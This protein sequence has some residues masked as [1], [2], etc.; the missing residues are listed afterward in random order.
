[1]YALLCLWSCAQNG[2]VKYSENRADSIFKLKN[3][4]KYHNLDRFVPDTLSWDSRQSHYQEVDSTTF[5]KL[6][7][8]GNNKFS[9]S[10]NDKAF[11]YSWQDRDSNF[12]DVIILTQ[13][14]GSYCDLLKY[15]IFDKQGSYLSSF[16][17]AASCSDAGWTFQGLGRQ[18][19]NNVFVYNT[20]ESNELEIGVPG[21]EKVVS[22][23]LSHKITILASGKVKDVVTYRKHFTQ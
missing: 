23:S 19:G 18:M 10:G 7:K 4:F 12:I 1:M 17:I 22:D 11:Y 8:Q 2:S 21:S 5:A 9:P 20:N 3:R 13:E 15:Y 14:E 6:F 16:D